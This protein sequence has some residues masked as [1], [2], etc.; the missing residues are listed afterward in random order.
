[1]QRIL[2]TSRERLF[3]RWE[4]VLLVEPLMVPR[5][6][7]GTALGEIATVPAVALF[8]ERAQA[9]RG[10]FAL[11]ATNAA[12]VA[13]ICRRLD[14]LPLAIELA[15]ARAGEL[16]PDRLLKLLERPLDALTE[17][18]KG[19]PD[20]HRTLRA[21]IDWSYGLLG[22][23]AR[24]LLARVGVFRGGFDADAA[25]AVA[26]ANAAA[27]GMEGTS[28]RAEGVV[29]IGRVGVETGLCALA[30]KHLLVV[31]QGQ[32]GAPRFA[33]LETIREYALERLEAR[34]EVEAVRARH[35]AHFLALA[36]MNGREGASTGRFDEEAWME[37]LDREAANI[38]EALRW[39]ASGAANDGSHANG[40]GNT[41]GLR[42]CVALSRYWEN[43]RHWR[44]AREWLTTFV[45][46]T[47]AATAGEEQPGVTRLR[48]AGHYHLGL[49]A[50]RQADLAVAR[51]HLGHTLADHQVSGD[52]AGA[53]GTLRWL[54]Q[55]AP[56]WVTAR[57]LFEESLAL[58]HRERIAS[59]GVRERGGRE[60]NSAVRL[61]A[62]E[63]EAQ[64]LLGELDLREGDLVA[65]RTRLEDA[66]ALARVTAVGGRWQPLAVA[67]GSLGNVLKLMGD[68]RA[69][70]TVQREHLDLARA[71]G[72]LRQ[73]GEAVEFLADLALRLGDDASGS[74]GLRE[75]LALCE[76]TGDVLGQA[77]V[78]NRIGE[79][80]RLRSRYGE[81]AA[82]YEHSLALYRELD[83][84]WGVAGRLVNL[85]FVTYRQ[86]DC[87]AALGR[88]VE[89]LAV[90]PDDRQL[91]ALA[92][93]GI[94]GV[95]AEAGH[96]EHAGDAARLLGAARALLAIHGVPLGG[97]EVDEL[98][99]IET[100]LRDGL[101][102]RRFAS[103]VEE[104]RDMATE[105]D[106]VIGFATRL[107]EQ[108]MAA[109]EG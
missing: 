102:D 12:V 11:D 47:A 85:G 61:I 58:F 4:H 80:E 67:L 35:A 31:R 94:A 77:R 99:Q 41:S 33:L 66:V 68:L 27:T 63:S 23:E 56:D 2:A 25:A 62:G 3:V 21:S 100:T 82:A 9:A 43:R 84:R 91:V 87:A 55:A 20:R 107:A 88:F 7:T 5:T 70:T 74:T 39:L 52:I 98:A 6:E 65:A 76:R 30:D 18:L 96:T 22:A 24:A 57:R 51:E 36:E 95:A 50:L 13:E 60:T 93:A 83:H 10:D 59:K 40:A 32:D 101:D 34:G 109:S 37:R 38:R 53:A 108:V 73:E 72:D 79:E 45:A 28:A 89:I 15:A 78:L 81:A 104:G 14:G 54:G 90:T 103:L 48:T 71:H 19:V 29:P 86:G 42:L 69:A 8:V 92:A 26:G 44:E 75:T 64:R 106:G 49:A 97:M 1:V 16:P 105:V 17:S 46:A